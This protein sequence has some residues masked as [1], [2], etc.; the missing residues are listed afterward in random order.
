M[1]SHDMVASCITYISSWGRNRTDQHSSSQN[2]VLFKE[3]HSPLGEEIRL[4]HVVDYS[5]I[6]NTELGAAANQFSQSSLQIHAYFILHWT[7]LLVTLYSKRRTQIKPVNL[8]AMQNQKTGIRTLLLSSTS[9]WL[10]SC[11]IFEFFMGYYA[12]RMLS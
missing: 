4:H 2:S 6:Y 8:M 5:I 7:K 10:S 12:S 9:V 11:N 1:I 3:Q